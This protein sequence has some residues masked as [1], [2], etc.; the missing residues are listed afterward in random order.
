MW[1]AELKH[2]S[3]R[4]EW[5]REGKIITFNIVEAT[6]FCAG[7][8]SLPDKRL[9]QAK[10]EGKKEGENEMLII[11]L[12]TDFFWFIFV[13]SMETEIYNENIWEYRFK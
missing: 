1:S 7:S 2:T 6:F 13:T 3:Y 4:V 9:E 12:S 10:G 8:F 5:T 11:F